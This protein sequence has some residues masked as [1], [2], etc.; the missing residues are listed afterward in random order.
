MKKKFRDIIV[1]DVKYGW[2]NKYSGK[3]I[4]IWKHGRFG[5]TTSMERIVNGAK[6]NFN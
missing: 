4:V 2:Q 1:N 3:T 5:K 6:R